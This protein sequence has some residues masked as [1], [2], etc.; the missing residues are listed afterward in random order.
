VRQVMF[1]AGIEVANSLRTSALVFAGL[2]TTRTCKGI[3]SG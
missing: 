2:A 1:L 3:S